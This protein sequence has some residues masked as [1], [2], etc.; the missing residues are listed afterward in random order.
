MSSMDENYPKKYTLKN[1]KRRNKSTKRRASSKEHILD[2]EDRELDTLPVDDTN[3]E[4]ATK[5]ILAIN[6]D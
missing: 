2:Y 1:S 4:N 3:W 6:N 5:C